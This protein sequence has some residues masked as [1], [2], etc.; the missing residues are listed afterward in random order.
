MRLNFDISLIHQV[1]PIWLIRERCVRLQSLLAFP[2]SE[3]IQSFSQRWNTYA[4]EYTSRGATSFCSLPHIVQSTYKNDMPQP[5]GVYLGPFAD[6]TG[7][8]RQT[9][10][11]VMFSETCSEVL[12]LLRRNV[13]AGTLISMK[14]E[15]RKS[16]F[17]IDLGHWGSCHIEQTEYPLWQSCKISECNLR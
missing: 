12:V 5:C 11:R 2:F 9:A 6:G 1:Q 10:R 17:R 4:K 16:T 7:Y 13:S 15:L 14:I 3:K 8:T